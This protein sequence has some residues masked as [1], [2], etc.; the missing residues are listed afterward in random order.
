MHGHGARARGFGLVAGVLLTWGAAQA[1][2]VPEEQRVPLDLRRA[3][4][5]VDDMERS[6]AFYRDALGMV[7]TYDNWVLTPREA[8][9]PEEAEIARPRG[10][11]LPPRH[12]RTRV[13]PPG[14]GSRL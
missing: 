7:V 9:S 6:L 2:P 3:T 8:P 4:I 10:P 1:A 11:R 5:V 12:Q 13:Q 14:L